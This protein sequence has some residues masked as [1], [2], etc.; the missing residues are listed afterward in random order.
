MGEERRAKTR[1]KGGRKKGIEMKGRHTD[2]EG[3]EGVEAV[4]EDRGKN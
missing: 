4:G 2:R 3:G 1:R